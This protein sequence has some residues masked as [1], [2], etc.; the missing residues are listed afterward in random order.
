VVLLLD[1]LDGVELD[2]AFVARLERRLLGADLTD[3]LRWAV[4]AG[5]LAVTMLGAAPSIPV[6]RDVERL[7]AR[8]G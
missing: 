4:A 5:A 1:Q 8:A 7:L 2:G 3:A 6:R